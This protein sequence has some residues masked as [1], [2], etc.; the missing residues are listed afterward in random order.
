M[1]DLTE[2]LLNNYDFVDALCVAAETKV[3]SYL[4]RS[5][6]Y[7]F[8]ANGES[9]QLL[10]YFI[11]K[12]IATCDDGDLLFRGY[13]MASKMWSGFCHLAFGVRFLHTSLAQPMYELMKEHEA[14]DVE[15]NPDRVD[16]ESRINVNKYNL[17]AAAQTIFRS[18]TSHS[19]DIPPQFRFILSHVKTEVA[20]KFPDRVYQSIGGMIIL[21]YYTP[22]ITASDEYG[23]L[24]EEPSDS[25]LRT[26]VLV[27]KVLQNLAN[28]TLFGV[29]EEYMSTLN[30][31]ITEN[32]ERMNNYLD[33]ISTPNEESMDEA[34]F[35]SSPLPKDVLEI[36]LANIHR[37]MIL[38][39]EEII[40]TL[41]SE[42]QEEHRVRELVQFMDT[43]SERIGDPID[44][45]AEEE[46]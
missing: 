15:M 38:N 34:G 12:E 42:I 18:I 14:Q 36:S 4:G 7:V 33:E 46:V 28:G 24:K 3:A 29:K 39:R 26:L 9:T 40:E 17:M 35:A 27:A 23:I 19:D 30:D 45:Q 31:F 11:E 10:K 21:R 37:Y 2:L 41:H 5:L 1:F 32:Q 8:E 6:L 20:K 25:L 22:A 16:D 44:V 43:V 13:S